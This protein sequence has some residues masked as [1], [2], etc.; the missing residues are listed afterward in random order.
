[1]ISRRAAKLLWD[2]RAAGEAILEFTSEKTLDDYS[3]SRLLQAAVERQFQII[4]EAMSVLRRKSPEV[5]ERIPDLH[6]MVAF[7]NILAHE[8]DRV[9]TPVVWQTVKIEVPELLALMNKLL[10]EAEPP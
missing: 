2:V 6:K 8:Y 10:A 5:V 7:R 1:M 3:A 4:G 9:R